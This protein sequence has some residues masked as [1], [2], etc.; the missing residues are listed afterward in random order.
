MALWHGLGCWC[1]LLGVALASPWPWS[2]SRSFPK[3]SF[4]AKMIRE[5]TAVSVFGNPP[6]IAWPRAGTVR[7]ERGEGGD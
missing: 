4:D 1:L 5:A 3:I 6:C 2:S 7:Q